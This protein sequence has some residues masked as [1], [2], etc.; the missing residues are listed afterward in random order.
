MTTQTDNSS[1]YPKLLT[2][3]QI[4]D[5]I[6]NELNRPKKTPNGSI[7][8]ISILLFLVVGIGDISGINILYLIGVIFL[9][10]LGHFLG[11]KLFGY[12]NPRIFFIPGVGA[13]AGA[14]SK[15]EKAWHEIVVLLLG[16][17]PGL[18]LGITLMF[19]SPVIEI[20]H[21]DSL[22]AMLVFI[23][24]FNL[25]PFIPLDGGRV[26][27]EALFRKSPTLELLFRCVGIVLMLAF[28]VAVRA[29]I[30]AL[31]IILFAATLKET[32]KRS[33]IMKEV[34]EFFAQNR[35]SEDDQIHFICKAVQ[36][37]YGRLYVDKAAEIF[38]ESQTQLMG[39][40][41]SVITTI[42]YAV[43]V[44]CSLFFTMIGAAFH[45]G[46]DNGAYSNSQSMS[47]KL[48]SLIDSVQQDELSPLPSSGEFSEKK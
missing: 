29:V 3:D 47:P 36:N 9:H 14:D 19:F 35:L 44:V 12:T 10:E 23:N 25:L 40:M 31:F 37:E 13:A 45:Y 18:A 11:M 28:A 38:K 16:P 39:R 5:E 32:F 4:V 48:Q 27:A 42:T 15:S 8:I 24:G 1:E 43:I 20:P 21:K 17:L 6:K 26:M 30:W 41:G 2:N 22:I 7:F 46:Y 33:R 34:R